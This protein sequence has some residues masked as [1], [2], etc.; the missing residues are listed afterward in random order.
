VRTAAKRI[1]SMN[2][3]PAGVRLDSGDLAKDSQWVRREL[4]RIGWKDVKIFASG[5]LDETR[6]AALIAKHAAIDAFGVGTALATPGDAPHLNLIYKLV[7]VER[8]GIIREAAKLS[9]AKVTYPG[10][11][12]VFRYSAPSG[13]YRHDRIA[14]EGEPADGGEPMLVEVMRGGRRV[15]PAQPVA[16]LRARCLAGLARLPKTYRQIN[17]AA[18]YPVRYTKR[19][20]ALLE[21]L[22]RRIRRSAL[23]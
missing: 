6:I 20:E 3:K 9:A 21:K 17:R 8:G 11:K 16:D 7:E 4:D 5:D 23:K 19:L 14:L 22:R 1:I 12:Q 15:A 18:V 13:E 2:R 10:R